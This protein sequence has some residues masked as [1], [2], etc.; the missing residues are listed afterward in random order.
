M[1]K[2]SRDQ[3]ATDS[4]PTYDMPNMEAVASESQPYTAAGAQYPT[5]VSAR[6]TRLQGAM[7]RVKP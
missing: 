2:R 3:N 5:A 1:R 4:T 6:D 7:R